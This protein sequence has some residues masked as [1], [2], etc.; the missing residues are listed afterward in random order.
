MGD[1]IKKNDKGEGVE[2]WGGL[3]GK[4]EGKWQFGRLENMWQDNIKIHLK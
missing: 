3:V 4:L 1:E 2:L